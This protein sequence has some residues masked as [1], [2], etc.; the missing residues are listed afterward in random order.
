MADG[1]AARHVENLDPA[2]LRAL[3]C[4]SLTSQDFQAGLAPLCRLLLTLDHRD[5]ERP[6]V[7]AC[8]AVVYARIGRPEAARRALRKAEAAAVGPRAIGALRLA[9]REVE[10][11]TG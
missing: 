11:A 6:L 5:P 1:N 9:Q 2:S 8:L 4:R 10:A 3:A 7:L